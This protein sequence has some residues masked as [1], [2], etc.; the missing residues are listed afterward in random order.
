MQKSPRPLRFTVLGPVR[1]WRGDREIHLGS[2]QSRTLIALLLAHGGEVMSLAHLVDAM[3]GAAPPNTAVNAVHRNVGLLRRLIEPALP[4]RDPG[5]WLIR[6]AGG[7]RLAVGPESLDLLRL[8]ALAEQGRREAKPHLFREALDLWQGTVADGIDALVRNDTVFTA[9]DQELTALAREAA[10]LALATGDAELLLGAV[11]RAADQAPFDE[12]LHARL[13]RLWAATGH[14]AGAL[15]TYE[16]LRV[17][18]GEELGITP[19]VEATDARDAVLRPA[20]AARIPAQLPADLPVFAARDAELALLDGLADL[21]GPVAVTGMPG[22][23]KT[24]L[25]VHWAHRVAGRFP[26]GQL[27]LNLRGFDRERRPLTSG[28]A[29]AALLDGLGVSGRDVPE[30][31]DARAALYRTLL[32]GRRMLVVLDDARDAGQVR[33]L[34]PGG[35]G[36]LVIVT[37]RAE[38]IGLAVHGAPV[39]RVPP[40]SPLGSRR[41]LERRLGPARLSADPVATGEIVAYC[42]GLPL[43]LAIV[44]A[45]AQHGPAAPLRVLAAELRAGRL[46]ALSAPGLADDVRASFALSVSSLTEHAAE[47]FAR[48]GH[49]SAEVGLS[50]AASELSAAGMLIEIGPGRFRMH[51]LLRLFARETAARETAAQ[52]TTARETAVRET[53]ARET[54]ARETAARETTPSG[55]AAPETAA[56]EAAA[57]RTRPASRQ[58]PRQL[59]AHT[60]PTAPRLTSPISDLDPTSEALPL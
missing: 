49:E 17:R 42:G 45:R 20:R 44:A 32:A 58:N 14:Q 55:T 39:I 30:T 38:P 15:A 52:E 53:P 47:A 16:R 37:G 8:R 21:A 48:L 4:V 2:P 3:W 51:E 35:G 26:G 11:R 56:R 46:D 27:Y 18:L 7:Y 33:P 43:A 10:D 40:L 57:P 24:T 50:S 9:L 23:G 29:L 41:M 36:C 6:S 12:A 54:T 31:V 28:E 60:L 19:G 13:I 1:A 22:V 5:S 59:P 34:L 25:A